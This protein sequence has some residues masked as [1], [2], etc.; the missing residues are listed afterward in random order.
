MQKTQK[1][2]RMIQCLPELVYK[3]VPAGVWHLAMD[4]AL[5]LTESLHYGLAPLS[6]HP[7]QVPQA[8]LPEGI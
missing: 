6:N 4:I 1:T 5:I 3:E 2:I 7:H 8:W